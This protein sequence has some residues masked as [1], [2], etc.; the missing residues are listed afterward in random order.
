MIEPTKKLKS[1]GWILM[2]STWDRVIFGKVLDCKTSF[3]LKNNIIFIWAS[4]LLSLV[5]ITYGI[6]ILIVILAFEV[7]KRVSNNISLHTHVGNT[8]HSKIKRKGYNC[9]WK[10]LIK[11]IRTYDNGGNFNFQSVI[12][13]HVTVHD[14][15]QHDHF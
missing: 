3:H 14:V 2:N 5:I 4:W 12:I 15:F 8:D 1:L 13:I 10:V 9:N 6:L 7:M 11:I